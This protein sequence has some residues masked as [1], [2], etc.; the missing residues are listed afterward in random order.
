MWEYITL[1]E[2]VY[3]AVKS[4][5]ESGWTPMGRMTAPADIGNVVCL[6]CSEEAG[7]I[8]GQTIHADGGASIMNTDLPPEI[9]CGT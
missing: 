7:W 9:Q 3:R 4:W 2:P 1:P 8:T 6:L 5:N